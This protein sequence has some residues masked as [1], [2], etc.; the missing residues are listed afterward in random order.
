LWD[1][2]K[3]GVEELGVRS[4]VRY[5]R[6]INLEKERTIE[7]GFESVFSVKGS[8]STRVGYIVVS[9]C[10]ALVCCCV[11]LRHCMTVNDGLSR[12]NFA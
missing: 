2:R 6:G 5:K 12:T 7:R 1:S 4:G 11:L 3:G 10:S 9:W 8:N